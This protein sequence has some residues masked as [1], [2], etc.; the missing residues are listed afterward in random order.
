MSQFPPAPP[1]YDIGYQS[2]GAYGS[3]PTLVRLAMIFNFIMCGLDGVYGL[4]LAGCAIAMPIFLASEPRSPGDPPPWIMGI[5]LGG[6]AVL[7]LAVAT[8]KLIASLKLLRFKPN[9]AGWGLAAGIIGCTQLWCSYLCLIPVACGVFTIV[10]M[11][12]GSV[13]AYLR[14]MNLSPPAR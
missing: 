4:I 5:I 6:V 14:D 1:P 7:A 8:V 13:R 12:L 2:L 9:A 10:A 11:S 3:A